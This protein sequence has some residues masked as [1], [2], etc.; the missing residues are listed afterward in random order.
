MITKKKFLVLGA[1]GMAGHTI[2]TYLNES[3]HDVFGF[4]RVTVN[5]C[6]SIVGDA[7]DTMFLKTIINEGKFDA[8][9]NC[10][11]ILNQFAEQNNELA[12]YVNSYL[13]HLLAEITKN[14]TTQIIH[15][16][17]DC[18]FSGRIGNYTESSFPDGETFYDRSKAM[19]ELIDNKNITFRNSIVGPDLNE[20]GIGLLNWFM[21]QS[22]TIQGYSKVYWT[23]LTTLELAKIIEYAVIVKANGLFNMVNDHS[24]SKYELLCLFNRYLRKD[25]LNIVS[26]N[27]LV[28][29]KALKRTRFELDYIVPD[30]E[31]MVCQMSTWMKSHKSFYPHY[32]L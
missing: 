5:H 10:I 25:N 18:V 23:G 8:V 32:S 9:I 24:I 28:L 1:A 7:R 2:S 15:L 12:V 31:D 27:D 4:A 20:N 26:N 29:N 13:P 30:Y 19:G 3:G 11:G 16:S 6:R 17:T 21:K 22:G 14:A